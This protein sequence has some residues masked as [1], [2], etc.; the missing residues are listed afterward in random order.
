MVLCA[1]VVVVV[2]YRCLMVLMGGWAVVVL[3]MI[4][5]DVL[6]HVQRGP[7]T[8]GYGEGLKK[9]ECDE[10]AHEISLLRRID[11]RVVAVIS[12]NS[13]SGACCWL[14]E[15]TPAKRGARSSAA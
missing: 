7:R 14:E 4:V 6:V 3:R 8:G 5:P 15:I 11:G 2:G 1:V 12:N 13:G 10:S 9:H